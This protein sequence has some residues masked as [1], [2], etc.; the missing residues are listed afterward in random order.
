MYRIAVHELT[1]GTTN[2]RPR[3]NLRIATAI[4]HNAD[5]VLDNLLAALPAVVSKIPDGWENIK[6]VGIKTSGSTFLPVWT[7]D[8]SKLY[9]SDDVDVKVKSKSEKK[10]LRGEESDDSMMTDEESRPSKSAKKDVKETK[11]AEPAV[12]AAP[13]PKKVAVAPAPK[14]DKEPKKVLAGKTKE[15]APAKKKV[16]GASGRSSVKTSVIG[17]KSK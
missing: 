2:L 17:K 13:S 12:V 15:A 16:G 3:S 6:S 8:P 4:H 11:K 5:Q 9:G 14:A 7:V 1:L 10:R